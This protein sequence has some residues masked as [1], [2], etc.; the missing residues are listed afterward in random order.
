MAAGSKLYIGRKRPGKDNA[1]ITSR[2][3]NQLFLSLCL[4]LCVLIATPT[5]ADFQV[6]G[7]ATPLAGYQEPPGTYEAFNYISPDG[8]LLVSTALPRPWYGGFYTYMASRT[9]DQDNQCWGPIV[10]LGG[11]IGDGS[12]GPCLSPDG[13]YLFYGFATACQRSHLLPGGGWSGGELILAEPGNS[14]SFNGR[15]LFFQRWYDDLWVADYNSLTDEFY[16]SRGVE[17]VNTTEYAEAQPWIS[18]DGKTLIFSSNRSGGYGGSDLYSATRDDEN[19]PWT[20]IKN[21]GPYVNTAD[22]ESLGRLAED[23]GSLIFERSVDGALSYGHFQAT[24]S[25]TTTPPPIPEPVSLVS[26]LIG[27]VCIGGY[28]KRRCTPN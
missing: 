11:V 23:A 13:N 19:G 7:P 18:L 14:F 10:P 28:L 25:E 4:G 20:N 21:L 15:Q 24:V 3:F 16:N 26:G 27:F 2:H 6:V 1:M 8:R 12:M 17:S 9:W 5:L 22:N